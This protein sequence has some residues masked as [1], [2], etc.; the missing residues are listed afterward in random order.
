MQQFH[1]NYSTLLLAVMR[2]VMSVCYSH[3]GI[4]IE[5][6]KFSSK[7]I[8]Q[9]E[10]GILNI[11]YNIIQKFIQCNNKYGLLI[12]IFRIAEVL[13]IALTCSNYYFQFGNIASQDDD[14]LKKINK[15]FDN[16]TSLQNLIKQQNY[17]VIE[18][19]LY[20]KSSFI[21]YCTS[22]EY[23]KWYDN[24]ATEPFYTTTYS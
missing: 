10:K 11:D 6:F 17:I 12:D 19:N 8:E 1:S 22:E 4:L 16:T 18:H 7:E 13:K 21:H 24:G 20:A 14:L 3:K 9:F 23:Q 15:F 5:E 2:E